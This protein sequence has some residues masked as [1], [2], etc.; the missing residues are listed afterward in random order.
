VLAPPRK[1]L[2]KLSDLPDSDDD[3]QVITF[4]SDVSVA[5]HV[6]GCRSVNRRNRPMSICRVQ[7]NCR[8]LL[9]R[10]IAC[11]KPSVLPCAC[12]LSFCSVCA[13]RRPTR[14]RGGIRS[15]V[16]RVWRRFGVSLSLLCVWDGTATLSL[17]FLGW[18]VSSARVCSGLCPSWP[19]HF[20]CYVS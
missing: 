3:G 7:A 4:C 13:A 14:S 19:Y 6:S 9:V 10:R 15:A 12:A 20:L 5:G 17:P 8:P 16:R 18:N 2:R 11:C 1:R